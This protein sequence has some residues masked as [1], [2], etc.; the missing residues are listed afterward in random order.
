MTDTVTHP[1]KW[2]QSASIESIP[3]GGY[4]IREIVGQGYYPQ[5][6]AAFSTLDEALKWLKKAM[7]K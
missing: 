5:V 4:V 2:L 1:E 6:L 7:E 3:H